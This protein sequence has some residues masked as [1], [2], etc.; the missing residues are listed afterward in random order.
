[1]Q[2]PA[3]D[4]RYR[5]QCLSVSAAL[6]T[7]SSDFTSDNG[8]WLGLCHFFGSIW[9]YSIYRGQHAIYDRVKLYSY[10]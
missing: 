9:G 2:W 3:K 10:S 1:V 5:L 8:D 4:R 6:S 7:P